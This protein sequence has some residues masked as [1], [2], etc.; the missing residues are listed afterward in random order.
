VAGIALLLWWATVWALEAGTAWY[1]RWPESHTWAGL[2]LAGV[3]ALRR[4]APRTTLVLACTVYPIGYTLIVWH[5]GMQSVF[6]LLPLLVAAF[7]VTRAGR[8]GPVPTV[9]GSVLAALLLDQGIVGVQ[10]LLDGTGGT[11]DLSYAALVVALTAGAGVL[12][13]A[14][15]RLDETARSLESSNAALRALQ[16]VR[17][18]QAVRAERT[19]IARE[20]HDVLAHHVS[21]IVVR[22]Q[23]ADRVG[24]RDPEAYRDAIR[25]IVPEGKEALGSMRAV[26]RVL[27]DTGAAPRAPLP[28]L[29]ALGPVVDRVRGAGLDVTTSVAATEV[30]SPA[31][32]LA[33]VRIAQE[34]LTNVLTHSLA[35]RAD[36]V[37][38]H[39]GDV[40]VLE[41]SDPGPP[42]RSP[43][44]VDPAAA[45]GNGLL[46]MRERAASCGGTLAAGP[47]ADGRWLVR[48]EVPVP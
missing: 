31:I 36:L 17:A 1:P 5:E 38:R 44:P 45:G 4:L 20:L 37:L 21:A 43:D 11:P 6:H 42:R 41:V 18:Q 14:F 19:R 22:A 33:V 23:A 39:V 26:V 15:H 32:G 28:G 24:A 25:W 40:L 48:M 29:D 27:R 2:W 34:A 7:A 3:L 10:M 30:T 16:E 8:L 9:V 13:A 12:G 35:T 46:H 47:T